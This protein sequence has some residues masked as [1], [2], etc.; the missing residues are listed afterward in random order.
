[1]RMTYD[2]L[3]EFDATKECI[4][5]FARDSSCLAN[6]IKDG[7]EAQRNRKKALFV[8]RLLTRRYYGVAA[9]PLLPPNCGDS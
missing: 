4:E 9:N 5:D 2:T 1:M 6:N 7:D 8:M 3:R